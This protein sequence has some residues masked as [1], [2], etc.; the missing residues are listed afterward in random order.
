M[1][2]G[3]RQTRKKQTCELDKRASQIR[4]L[5]KGSA[6]DGRAARELEIGG[7]AREGKP[8]GGR[9]CGARPGAC[10]HLAR[11]APRR[12]A[13]RTASGPVTPAQ[14]PIHWTGV[15]YLQLARPG[16]A[17]HARPSPGAAFPTTIRPLRPSFVH[18]S[19]YRPRTIHCGL[20]SCL[21]P[22]RLWAWAWPDRVAIPR[23]V[24]S[25][26][27]SGV[28]VASGAGRPAVPRPAYTHRGRLE[29]GGCAVVCQSQRASW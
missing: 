16:E 20:L 25:V 27:V 17:A 15:P 8:S 9:G 21:F 7:T 19:A 4:H 14:H 23:R 2:G 18:A 22:D 11:L 13:R 10:T 3:R 24:F 5:F 28:G 26:V 1:T 6:R 12:P 29:R